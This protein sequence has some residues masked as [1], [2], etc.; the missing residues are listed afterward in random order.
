M[1][2]I[3]IACLLT[4]AVQ[5]VHA[6]EKMTIRY[7]KGEPA[8]AKPVED[9][10]HLSIDGKTLYYQQ[11]V[12]VDSNLTIPVIFLRLQEF[13]AGKNF[14][15]NFGDDRL[16]RVIFTTTQDLNEN[17]PEDDNDGVDAYSAQFSITVDIK[18][19][20][21]RYTIND[22]VFFVP[23]GTGFNRRMTL[24]DMYQKTTGANSKRV[25]REAVK[26]MGSFDKY[27]SLLTNEMHQ[28]VQHKDKI[29]NPV[30]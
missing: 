11:T 7:E 1:K 27:L 15:M 19:G 24:Y 29:Y 8:P 21:Y 22:V 25:A 4:C 17:G 5:C 18:K 23:T 30:F 10:V 2:N 20:R 26:F 6:Q 9:S 28:A 13:G 16:G 12:K 3:L 14:Q